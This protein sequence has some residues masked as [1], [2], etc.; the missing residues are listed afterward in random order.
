MIKVIILD[1]D[2]VIVESLDIKD[3]AFRDLFSNYPEHIDEIMKYQ[4]EYNPFS[5]YIKFEHIVTNILGETYD[6]ERKQELGTRFSQL[7]QQKV[8]ECPYVKGAEEFLR[9]FS[10]IVPLYVASS[11]PQVELKEILKARGIDGYFKG[12]YGTPWVKYDVFQEVMSDEKVTPELV[13]YVG[14]SNEDLAVAEKTGVFFIGRVNQEIFRDSTIFTYPDL[15]GAKEHL[16]GM[17]D[18][19]GES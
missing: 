18:R 19:A 15:V 3:Q 16:Q 1:F 9:Y 7:V 5:R 12:I 2:G 13:A 11:S 14:D 17:I 4:S 8:I 10:A 6:E